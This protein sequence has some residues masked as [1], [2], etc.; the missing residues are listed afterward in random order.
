M[1]LSW[2]EFMK[3]FLDAVPQLELHPDF[4]SSGSKK[5]IFFNRLPLTW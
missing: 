2:L 4:K 5:Y 3:Q 1:F